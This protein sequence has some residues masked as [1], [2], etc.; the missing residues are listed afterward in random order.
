MKSLISTAAVILDVLISAASS[1]NVKLQVEELAEA[2][3]THISS[4]EILQQ[5]KDETRH[6]PQCATFG[7]KKCIFHRKL[8]NE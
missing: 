3:G 6:C 2:R 7:P 5:T 4:L 1:G 8:Y